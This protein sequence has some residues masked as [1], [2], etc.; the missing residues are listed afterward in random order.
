M[1]ESVNPSQRL[2]ITLRYLATGNTYKDV[3]FSFWTCLLLGR[4]RVPYLSGY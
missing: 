4:Q 3:K 2:S 1:R